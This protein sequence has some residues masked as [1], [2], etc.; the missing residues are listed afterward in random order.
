MGISEV[1]YID[2]YIIC[3]FS[4]IYIYSLHLEVYIWYPSNF[5]TYYI[6]NTNAPYNCLVIIFRLVIYII[7][8]VVMLV[9]IVDIFFVFVDIGILVI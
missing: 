6:G 7:L 3:G 2:G 8:M 4:C 5:M 1:S 9:I